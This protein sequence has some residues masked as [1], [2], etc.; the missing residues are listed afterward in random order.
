MLL[1]TDDLLVKYLE[2]DE[3]LK[4]GDFLNEKK[5]KVSDTPITHRQATTLDEDKLLS[6]DR[7]TKKSW[8]KFSFKEFI[9]ILIVHELKKFGVKHEQLKSLWE[10]FFKEPIRQK[11]N[12]ISVNK[13]IGECAVGC[14]FAQVEIKISINSGGGV[15]FYDPSH[16]ILLDTISGSKPQIIIRLND[17]VN[18][19]LKQMGKTPISPIWTQSNLVFD[20]IPDISIKEQELLKIIRDRNFSVVKIKKKDGEIAIVYAETILDG[21]RGLNQTDL[22]KMINAKDY[23]DINIIRRDGK[24]VNFKVEETIKL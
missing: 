16:S 21:S 12:E 22:I 18:T 1:I 6:T 7:E 20:T 23:Q 3:R 9:Y 5:F 2:A 4:L 19:L 15:I 8:R 11:I 24:I 14:T 17:L 13:F 10:S